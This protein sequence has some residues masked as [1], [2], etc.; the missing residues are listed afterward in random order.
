MNWTAEFQIEIDLSAVFA[1]SFLLSDHNLQSISI[2]VLLELWSQCLNEKLFNNNSTERCLFDDKEKKRIFNWFTSCWL[3]SILSFLY[4]NVSPRISPHIDFHW[5]SFSIRCSHSKRPA[6]GE[7]LNKV[8]QKAFVNVCDKI[9]SCNTFV[10][11]IIKSLDFANTAMNT[12]SKWSPSRHMLNVM[13]KPRQSTDIYN[14]DLLCRNKG[15]TMS[16]ETQSSRQ[17]NKRAC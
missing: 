11:R 15:K 3:D 12:A 6:F 9:N 16:Y 7:H 10:V 4:A 2:T 17:L 1:S 8:K 5:K 14:R 13:Q